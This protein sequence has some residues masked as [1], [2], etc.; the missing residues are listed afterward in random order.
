MQ[1]KHLKKGDIKLVESKQLFKWN[2]AFNQMD[3]TVEEGVWTDLDIDVGDTRQSVASITILGLQD[4][5]EHARIANLYN[6][7]VSYFDSYNCRNCMILLLSKRILKSGL[8]IGTSSFFA[9]SADPAVGFVVGVDAVLPAASESLQT[10]FTLKAKSDNSVAGFVVSESGVIVIHTPALSNDPRFSDINIDATIATMETR[11]DVLEAVLT[12][13]FGTIAIACTSFES[14]LIPIVHV[15]VEKD[16]FNYSTNPTFLSDENI[17]L[18]AK[19]DLCNIQTYNDKTNR[20]HTYITRIGFYDVNQRLLAIAKVANADG[21]PIRN[22][23][24][25]ALVF[26]V[27]LRLR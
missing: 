7:P 16:E 18:E 6:F 12:P 13:I 17:L 3:K 1:F 8:T 26:E 23:L 20:T 15:R 22:D 14:Q 19:R 5:D 24:T 4:T 10:I 27:P 25:E 2:L 21:K 9:V 11:M